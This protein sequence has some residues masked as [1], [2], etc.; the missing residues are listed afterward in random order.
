V[1]LQSL[2]W[3]AGLLHPSSSRR[4]RDSDV[5]EVADALAG[6]LN[7]IWNDDQDRL[8]DDQTAFD[9]FRGLLA[10]L[11]HRQNEHGMEL[12]GRIGGLA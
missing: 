8:R 7:V 9:A 10:W 3:F 6:L 12:E 2:A 1:R 4:P 5:D 11:V